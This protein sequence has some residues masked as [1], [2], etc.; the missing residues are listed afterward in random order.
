MDRLRKLYLEV[1][2]Q[3]GG[4]QQEG[5]EVVVVQTPDSVT[6]CRLQHVLHL[7]LPHQVDVLVEDMSHQLLELIGLAEPQPY[8]G[9]A[10]IHEGHLMTCPVVDA[11]V[12]SPGLSDVAVEFLLGSNDLF[13]DDFIEEGRDMGA[14][15]LV[16]VF[17]G[18]VAVAHWLLD[19]RGLSQQ[20]LQLL[21][22]GL[23]D[24]KFRTDL[25][26]RD[27]LGLDGLDGVIFTF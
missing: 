5:Q 18:F 11:G 25:S 2:D 20:L 22:E 14:G 7:H 1:T 23:E 12:G 3:L 16:P 19:R 26:V 9:P 17:E 8:Q 27:L 21:K 4:S 15:F 13:R 24:G 10:E 6:A